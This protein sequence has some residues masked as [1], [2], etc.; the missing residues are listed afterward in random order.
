[1]FSGLAGVAQKKGSTED[2]SGGSKIIV[3]AFASL[4]LYHNVQK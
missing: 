2:S 4:L 3:D 1:M